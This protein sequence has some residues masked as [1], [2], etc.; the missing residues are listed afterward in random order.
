MY[1]V[2][3]RLYVVSTGE[4]VCSQYWGVYVVSTGENVC[5][6]YRGDCMQSVLGIVCSLYWGVY[7]VS[8]GD[9]M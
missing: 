3:R 5:S 8:T 1:S 7:A 4:T 2:L 9:C 6:Q